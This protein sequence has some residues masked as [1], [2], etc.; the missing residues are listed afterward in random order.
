MKECEGDCEKH[1]GKVKKVR[2]VSGEGYDWGTF[3]Y[4][5]EAIGRDRYHG[6]DVEV[7]GLEA[8]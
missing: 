4:C 5:D 2:V 3:Y 8:K 1:T 6:F 7:L